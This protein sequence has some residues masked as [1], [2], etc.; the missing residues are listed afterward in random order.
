MAITLDPAHRAEGLVFHDPALDDA[1]AT[2][3]LIV[4][5]GRFADASIPAVDSPPA[6]ARAMAA[7]F[8]D[9]AAGRPGFANPDRPLGS[10]SLLLSE[11]PDPAPVEGGPVPAATFA[12]VETA[13]R[14]WITRAGR[15]PG[16]AAILFMSSHGQAFLRRTAIL[17][18]DYGSDPLKRFAGMTEVEQLAR[19][20]AT[21]DPPEKVL[22]FDCCR[23]RSA[24][25]LAEDRS[26]GTPLIDGRDPL[27]DDF[28]EVRPP[29]LRSTRLG[30]E[31]FGRGTTLF[32]TAL[33]E[34]L[35][36][37]AAEPSKDWR[38]YSTGLSEATEDILRL[39]QQDGEPLQVPTLE[40]EGSIAIAQIPEPLDVPVFVAL[41]PGHGMAGAVFRTWLD[42]DPEPLATLPGPTDGRPYLRLSLPELV[43]CRVTATDAS[44]ALI[45]EIRLKPRMPRHIATLL[46]GPAQASVLVVRGSP[47][48]TAAPGGLLRINPALVQG[49]TQAPLVRVARVAEG[50][51]DWPSDALSAAPRL[52]QGTG[53]VGPLI[54]PPALPG[55]D[56]RLAPGRWVIRASRADG[57]DVETV[58]DLADGDE[59]TLDLPPPQ[60]RHEWLGPAVMA[61][62]IG[63][64]DGG[65]DG[66]H[67][68]LPAPVLRLVGPDRQP[69]TDAQAARA[70]ADGRLALYRLQDLVQERFA[71]GGTGPANRPVWADVQGPGWRERCFVPLQGACAELV[72]LGPGG[73]PD[74]W[75]VELLVD[76]APPPD[77]SHVAGYA[78][79]GRL[80]PLLAFLA[81]RSFPKADAALRSIAADLPLRAAL[82]GTVA[83]PLAALAAAQI[84][85]ATG[86]VR[87]LDLGEDWLGTLPVRLP[88]LPDGPAVLGHF[89]LRQGRR[90]EAA[91]A[92]A[93]AAERGVPVYSLALDWLAQ[94]LGS[95]RLPQA[96]V[97]R[98][99]ALRSDPTRAFTVIRLAEGE[100]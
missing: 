68:A 39:W 92:F 49:V 5:V 57:P 58:L 81:R 6:S 2:H 34:A 35:S 75:R 61:G 17:F 28:V 60:S 65:G 42:D 33:L 51:P 63:P 95:L 16:S 85:V 13:L 37:L 29:V 47:A 15:N 44:G 7:W 41:P 100:P 12:A 84:A 94:G 11:G 76:D 4:G 3:V 87:A 97:W 53:S 89:L 73:A 20:L 31:A 22:I 52:R 26:F 24:I 48:A 77:R 30:A 19:A 36:G 55:A 9:G 82:Q 70:H 62:V 64:R 18:Q 25:P 99:L 98:D 69:V 67:Q 54:P 71:P 43:P 90:K 96:G 45:G 21:L 91:A 27:P 88:T 56:P 8:L 86:T 23:T 38:I 72:R 93:A 74:P 40:S 78:V 32:T 14:G 66:A 1:A 10:L 83:N 79:T 59:V 80:G 46:P 50:P